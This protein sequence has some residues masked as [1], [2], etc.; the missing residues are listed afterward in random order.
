M[1]SRTCLCSN[2]Q[3]SE[4]DLGSPQQS[5]GG[6]LKHQ[7]DSGYAIEKFLLAETSIGGQQVHQ[8]RHFMHYFQTDHKETVASSS[9]R[10][11]L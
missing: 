11:Q 6:T 1:F 7:K 2:K 9:L 10:Q 3:A 4:A 5:D 8:V